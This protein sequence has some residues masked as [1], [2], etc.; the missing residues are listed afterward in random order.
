MLF[1][2]EHLFYNFGLLI[3]VTSRLYDANL[4]LAT[5]QKINSR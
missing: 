5:A 4:H 3:M 1:S 2:W